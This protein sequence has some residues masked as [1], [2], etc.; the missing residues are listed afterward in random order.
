MFRVDDGGNIMA[1][2]R[3]VYSCRHQHII[4]ELDLETK[5][6]T[7]K[8]ACL[9]GR[10]PWFQQSLRYISTLSQVWINVFKLNTWYNL[11]IRGQ[12]WKPTVE[13]EKTYHWGMQYSRHLT[14]T[15]GL[16][17]GWCAEVD[18]NRLAKGRTWCF[19]HHRHEKSNKSLFS[20]DE[21]TM[22]LT[23]TWPSW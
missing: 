12:W 16:I 14:Q 5:S 17:P 21:T 11:P 4:R 6:S 1:L 20:S 13:S 3:W 9:N 22:K 15:L 23:Q 2:L 8:P 7:L 18:R 10:F 19:L